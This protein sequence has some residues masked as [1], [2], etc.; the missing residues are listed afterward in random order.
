MK[1]IRQC[2]KCK[3]YSEDP[4]NC[5]VDV[6]ID[7]LDNDADIE[8]GYEDDRLVERESWGY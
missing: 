8:E 3:R 6:D 7:E 1:N 2:I 4:E 5:C